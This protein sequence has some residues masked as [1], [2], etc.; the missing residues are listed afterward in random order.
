M[1]N[2]IT[3]KEFEE[4]YPEV[5]TYGLEAYSPV[6]LEN[7]VV[8]IDKEWNGE[9]YTVKRRG[10]RKNIQTSAGARRSGR[11]R[12]SFTVEN[13]WLQRRVLEKKNPSRQQPCWG[14]FILY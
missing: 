9:V 2:E 4:R 1:L 11:R 6:Y 13:N 12:R 7:G 5:S 14:F 3:K 10:K 8:L